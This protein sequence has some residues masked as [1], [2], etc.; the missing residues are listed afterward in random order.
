MTKTYRVLVVIKNKFYPFDNDHHPTFAAARTSQS[1]VA[2]RYPNH[3][4]A[5]LAP[6]GRVLN[7]QESSNFKAGINAVV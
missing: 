7:F 4:T 5:I 1:Y 6:D 2:K 3:E